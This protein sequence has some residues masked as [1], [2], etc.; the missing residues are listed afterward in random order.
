MRI[1]EAKYAGI[2][3]RESLRRPKRRHVEHYITTIIGMVVRAIETGIKTMGKDY[4]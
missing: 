4:I 3:G 2:G 1:V